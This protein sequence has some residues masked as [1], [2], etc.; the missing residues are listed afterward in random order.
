MAPVRLAM[1][2]TYPPQ[3]CGVAAH[4]GALRES[5]LGRRPGWRVDVVAIQASEPAAYGP[6][7]RAAVS[8]HAPSAVPDALAT[9]ARSGSNLLLLH[10]E[11]GLWPPAQ[12][13][14]LLGSCPVPVLTVLHNLP[15]A[16]G[17]SARPLIKYLAARS[18][19]LIAPIEAV[20]MLLVDHYAIPA[21]KVLV[22][23]W[24]YN[25]PSTAPIRR[26][27][28]RRRLSCSG[29]QVLL[30]Y[31]F[32]GPG[33]GIDLAV[34][35]LGRLRER[36]PNVLYLVLG[37]VHFRVPDRDA[38]LADLAGLVERR[39]LTDH[40][41]I[42]PR[43]ASYSE[44]DLHLAAA[45]LY[46]SPHRVPDRNGQTSSGTIPHAVLRGRAFVSVAHLYAEDMAAKGCGLLA[47]ATSRGLADAVGRLLSDPARRRAMERRAKEVGRRLTWN[48]VGAEYV[49]AVESVLGG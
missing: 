24:P 18:T 9:V 11:P 32:L 14:R 27:D 43:Y 22:V 42:H 4:A 37:E 35:G 47:D 30:T 39:G 48:S 41:R 17:A 26:T 1:M 38:F 3:Q 10:Y 33:K 34:S 45:D 49:A 7:V 5:L 13:C 31:G 20:R 12:L 2:G 29:R 15:L 25:G 19:R 23:P 21:E 28:A 16:A 6:E 46:L 8:L 36:F 40:V 44:L